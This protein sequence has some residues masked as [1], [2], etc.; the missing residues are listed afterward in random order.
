M[1]RLTFSGAKGD[2][3]NDA[4][5]GGLGAS[6]GNQ[7]QHSSAASSSSS[8]KIKVTTRTV[9]LEDGTYG[10]EDVY[11][12]LEDKD[13]GQKTGNPR[14][15]QEEGHILLSD[16]RG[17]NMKKKGERKSSLLLLRLSA[18]SYVVKDYTA[19]RRCPEERV[20]MSMR[21]DRTSYRT[22]HTAVT[23][24]T[25]IYSGLQVVG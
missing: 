19:L 9:I 13:G 7:Q 12:T 22:E 17:E 21:L 4:S 23:R 5:S 3:E 1:K 25:D 20:D 11:E 8:P 16:H 6:S 14:D 24:R 2:G 18:F 15:K 10:T